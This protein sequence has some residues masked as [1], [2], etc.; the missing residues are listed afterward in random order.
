MTSATLALKAAV[1]PPTPTPAPSESSE[2]EVSKRR[3]LSAAKHSTPNATPGLLYFARQVGAEKPAM[4]QAGSPFD[5]E[6]QMKMFVVSK[7]PEPRD[8]SYANSLK[9]WIEH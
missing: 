7:I 1:A 5:Y 3:I 4:L 2:T 6:R 8:P 9:N